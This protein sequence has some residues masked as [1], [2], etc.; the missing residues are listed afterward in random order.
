MAD[1]IWNLFRSCFGLHPQGHLSK[2]HT[3]LSSR[4]S[5]EGRTHICPR[6]SSYSKHCSMSS[7]LSSALLMMTESLF[8]EARAALQDAHTI[9]SYSLANI[10]TSTRA[11]PTYNHIRATHTYNHTIYSCLKAGGRAHACYT[12][13]D[14]AV[15]TSYLKAGAAHIL[16]IHLDYRLYTLYSYLRARARTHTYLLHGAVLHSAFSHTS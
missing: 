5:S 6:S 16:A 8:T 15:F 3:G 13:A 10:A 9:Y 1:H 14:I 4:S 11:T 2:L 7:L 12:L